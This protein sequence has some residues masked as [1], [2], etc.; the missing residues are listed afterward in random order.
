MQTPIH[1][2]TR[3]QRYEAKRQEL[4]N[5][6]QELRKAKGSYQRSVIRAEILAVARELQ[7]LQDAC[8]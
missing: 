2:A 1:R 8:D 4:L 7:R 5:L 6:K 3:K